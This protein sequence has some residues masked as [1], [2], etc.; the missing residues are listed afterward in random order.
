[1]ESGHFSPKNC[2]SGLCI[3]SVQ[4][5][6]AKIRKNESLY[7]KLYETN[8]RVC[9]RP[10]GVQKTQ[11]YGRLKNQFS[12]KLTLKGKI[13]AKIE[14]KKVRQKI[15]CL[16]QAPASSKYFF[17]SSKMSQRFTKKIF[18]SYNELH[19]YIFFGSNWENQRKY[20][21]S[22]KKNRKCTLGHFVCFFAEILYRGVI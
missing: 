10:V 5:E 7:E 4:V 14:V 22:T 18:K 3:G 19:W 16:P 17:I 13:W 1:M 6:M 11:N 8:P 12:R 2:I 9:F 20:A 21:I 15:S